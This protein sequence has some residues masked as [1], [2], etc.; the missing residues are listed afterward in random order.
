MICCGRSFL[1]V[2]CCACTTET[3]C[4]QEAMNGRGIDRHLFGLAMLAQAAGL[5]P[6]GQPAARSPGAASSGLPVEGQPEES[7]SPVAALLLGRTAPV[8]DLC[9]PCTCAGTCDCSS[10]L[11]AGE[12]ALIVVAFY[13]SGLTLTLKTA[14]AWWW[15]WG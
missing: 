2:I 5:L 15:V 4:R 7:L 13:P 12:V 3:L 11:N 8:Q 1:P 9:Q 14:R 10:V 6:S